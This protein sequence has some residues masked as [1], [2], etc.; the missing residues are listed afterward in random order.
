[1]SASIVEVEPRY[2]KLRCPD[3]GTKGEF[4]ASFKQKD[5]PN[6]CDVC[7]FHFN[8]ELVHDFRCPV[9]IARLWQAHFRALYIL[10]RYRALLN[11]EDER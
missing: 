1:M 3:C 2:T 8:H 5:V 9:C 7:R 6:G 11:R 4:P 10:L